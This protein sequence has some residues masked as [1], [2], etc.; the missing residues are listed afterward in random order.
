MPTKEVS[1]SLVRSSTFT[2]WVSGAFWAFTFT[3]AFQETTSSAILPT[4]QASLVSRATPAGIPSVITP[5][6]ERVRPSPEPPETVTT[7]SLL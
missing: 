4:P 5:L 1:E 2:L 6:P 7:A 3:S